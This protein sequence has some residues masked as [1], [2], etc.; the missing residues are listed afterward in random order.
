MLADK[1]K[2]LDPGL[3]RDPAFFIVYPTDSLKIG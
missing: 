2:T 3:R 1:A